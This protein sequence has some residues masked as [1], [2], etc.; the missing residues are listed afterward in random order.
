MA[1][2]AA[3][4]RWRCAAASPAAAT[5]R[6]RSTCSGAAG[7]DEVGRRS[8][9]P[10]TTLAGRLRHR[11]LRR[12]PAHA[13]PRPPARCSG[14]RAATDRDLFPLFRQAI[15]PALPVPALPRGATALLVEAF[16]IEEHVRLPPP[17][18][19]SS[20]ATR[21]A[22]AWPARRS[23]PGRSPR[24]CRPSTTSTSSPPDT[25][26]ADQHP[27]FAHRRSATPTGLRRARAVVP[28]SSSSRASCS[29][30]TRGSG[31]RSKVIVADIYDPFHLEQLEQAQR[32]RRGRRAGA[33]C[34]TT[35]AA[36]NE[37]LDARRLL[38]VRLAEAARL[39]AR[40]AGRPR[41]GST[42][43]NYDARR[44]PRARCIAVVPFGVADAAPVQ[45]APR[46]QGRRARHRRRRQ[47]HPLGRRHLQLVRPAH[48]R[49]APS[50]ACA[51][52][53]PDVR[54]FFLGL[55]HPNPDVPE[56]RMAVADAGAWPTSSA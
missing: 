6:P 10:R 24:R 43:E 25:C 39:L 45:T 27:D 7:G 37:Q 38:P 53:E 2:P 44:D 22:R 3:L 20:P 49:S 9:C 50:T 19:S 41:A 17:R 34:R 47:G 35:T 40:P 15:E 8:R 13:A 5:T 12:A 52:A 26:T 14:P 16:G 28:T 46:D 56:M 29:S 30:A 48:P 18:S 42:R 11:R 33:R 55:K 54:L 1:L 36:L 21:S 51:R 4:M 23:A 31:D 32:P